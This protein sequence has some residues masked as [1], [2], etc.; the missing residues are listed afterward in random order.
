MCSANVC[1]SPYGL[2]K[3]DINRLVVET[4]EQ[5]I[6]Y[7]CLNTLHHLQLERITISRGSVLQLLYN[8]S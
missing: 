8:A 7:C 4:L 2:Q 3:T 5:K 6:L 1:S